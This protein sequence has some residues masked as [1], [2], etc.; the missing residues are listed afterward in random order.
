MPYK[1]KEKT[2]EHN[3]INR[4]T[5][6]NKISSFIKEYKKTRN[7]RD[8]QLYFYDYPEVLEFDHLRDKEFAIADFSRKDNTIKEV[9]D[10]ISKCELVCANC[11]RIRTIKKHG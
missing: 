1:D 8:C 5:R 6:R 9:I 3:R 10:E 11:H 2:R 7:C 4:R